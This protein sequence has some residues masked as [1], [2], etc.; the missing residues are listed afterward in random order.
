MKDLFL[1]CCFAT[2]VACNSCGGITPKP[3]PSP[4]A[5]PVPIYTCEEMCDRYRELGCEE[6]QPTAFGTKCEDWCNNALN[7]PGFRARVICI[8]DDA[9][10]C[11]E[12]RECEE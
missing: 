1:V 2:I 10:S 7:V 4:D 5:G 8:I 3:T 6:G 9:E 11:I 12:A